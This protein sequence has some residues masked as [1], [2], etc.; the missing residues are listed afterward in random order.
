MKPIPNVFHLLA[1][2]L[3]SACCMTTQAAT[4]DLLR[5]VDRLDQ[6]DKQDFQSLIERVN[7]CVRS[8]DF[9]CAD[10]QLKKATG[11]ANDKKDK[12]TLAGAARA[13]ANERTLVA[14]EAAEERQAAEQ[15]EVAARLQETNRRKDICRSQCASG[16]R[17]ERCEAWR[18]SDDLWKSALEACESPEVAVETPTNSGPSIGESM[19]AGMASSLQSAG[20][21]ANIHNNMVANLQAQQAERQRQQQDQRERERERERQRDQ[22]QRANAERRDRDRE[23]S[24][25]AARSQA[26]AAELEQRAQRQREDQQ[27]Q[28]QKQ[29]QREQQEQQEQQ[30]AQQRREQQQRIA[31]AEQ[32]ST[33][34]TQRAAPSGSTG[35]S[36]G[37]QV[38]KPRM[39]QD[40]G[41]C[42]SYGATIPVGKTV[43][44][45]E[46]LEQ[47]RCE[48]WYGKS[49]F[50]KVQKITMKSQIR[51][52][53]LCFH[54][55]EA[56][57]RPIAE[58]QLE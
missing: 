1:A 51:E 29:K 30:Q 13:L 33:S 58:L 24:A 2:A 10:Q 9:A 35:N 56:N 46:S 57:Q 18:D 47:W 53:S 39:G 38:K 23:A 14:R 32:P 49:V 6:I 42:I 48:G 31:L 43:C 54:V 22:Q 36:T 4:S 28:Q 26:Q 3:L 40:D 25:Q 50:S 44:F 55:D 19:R 21:L 5:L 20:Q 45:A 34:G 11:L 7:G 15:R 41:P 37:S 52:K 12:E 17:Y 8:R 27:A 16:I